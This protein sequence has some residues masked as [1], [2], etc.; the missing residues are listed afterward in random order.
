MTVA[1][2]QGAANGLWTMCE[3]GT[4]N[5]NAKAVSLVGYTELSASTMAAIVKMPLNWGVV[6]EGYWLLEML[7]A[8]SSKVEGKIYPK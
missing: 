3:K 1:S 5:N 7:C 4:S 6:P 8:Y 2:W